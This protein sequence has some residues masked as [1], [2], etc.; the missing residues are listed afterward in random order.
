ME[1][2]SGSDSKLSKGNISLDKRSRIDSSEGSDDSPN[3]ATKKQKSIL[4]ENFNKNDLELSGEESELELNKNKKSPPKS[5]V[6]SR[7]RRAVKSRPSERIQE[8]DDSEISEDKSD[9]EFEVGYVPKPKK[10]KLGPIVKKNIKGKAGKKSSKQLNKDNSDSNDNESLPGIK[11]THLKDNQSGNSEG[12]TLGNARDMFSHSKSRKNPNNVASI[13]NHEEHDNSSDSDAELSDGAV[14]TNK[15]VR[16]EKQMRTNDESKHRVGAKMTSIGE[17]L[18]D[19]KGTLSSADSST[20]K[21][22][23]TVKNQP[24]QLDSNSILKYLKSTDSDSAEEGS[25]KLGS[26]DSTE[27]KDSDKERLTQAQYGVKKT[28]QK[29]AKSH[30]E[31]EDDSDEELAPK[32][33]ISVRKNQ[34]KKAKAHSE[35]EDDS[36]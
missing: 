27:N 14:E 24:N 18:S 30:S 21:P 20:N 34:Q 5:H 35:L 22:D 19:G 23:N 8:R 2:S 28:E 1:Y 33:Q 32:K 4:N 25:N 11:E 9:S 7:P 16:E 12:E 17:E 36:E 13:K 29:K 3:R 6:N 26:G 10:T 31:L 15:L